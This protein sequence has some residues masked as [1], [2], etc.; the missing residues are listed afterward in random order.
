MTRQCQNGG[1]LL[2]KGAVSEPERRDPP[3]TYSRPQPPPT[4]K[5]RTEQAQHRTQHIITAAAVP[6]YLPWLTASTTAAMLGFLEVNG[7]AKEASPVLTFKHSCSQEWVST[8]TAV[9][10]RSGREWMREKR[11][12]KY[13]LMLSGEG[14]GRLGRR[15]CSL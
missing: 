7:A 6:T 14:V 10:D 3:T 9:H 8:K 11:H 4:Y 2:A 1:A 13:S 15:R 5:H 12:A